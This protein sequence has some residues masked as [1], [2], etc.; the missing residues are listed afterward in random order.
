MRMRS[1]NRPT[2]INPGNMPLLNRPV[3]IMINIMPPA[4]KTTA[5]TIPII[6]R[7]GEFT[8]PTSGILGIVLFSADSPAGCFASSGSGFGVNNMFA[9]IKTPQC[10]KQYT[11]FR[12][13]YE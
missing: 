7:D 4:P 13:T 12:I 9:P 10:Y 5:K 2:I 1:I 6:T 3:F 8:G 11:M